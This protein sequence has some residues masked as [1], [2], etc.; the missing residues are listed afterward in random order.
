MQALVDQAC[1][2]ICGAYVYNPTDGQS[3]ANQVAEQIVKESQEKFGKEYKLQC[4]AIIL[5]K[6]TS[7]FHMSA[8]CFWDSASD[9]TINIKFEKETFYLIVTVFC[10]VRN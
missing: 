9:G 2:D 6:E 1:Q 4:L 7:G 5:N 8:S 10:E 3:K